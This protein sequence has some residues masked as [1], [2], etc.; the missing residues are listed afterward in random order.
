LLLLRDVRIDAEGKFDEAS[1]R[2]AAQLPISHEKLDTIE[3]EIEMTSLTPNLF[4]NSREILCSCVV[5]SRLLSRDYIVA[6]DSSGASDNHFSVDYRY[7]LAQVA[8][9]FTCNASYNA[10]IIKGQSFP[11]TLLV[12]HNSD[13]PV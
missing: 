13:G 9:S 2:L 12:R 6:Q 7:R 1:L 10:C 4:I 3:D 8:L 11:G 5:C